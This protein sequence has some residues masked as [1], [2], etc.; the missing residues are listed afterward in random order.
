MN[1]RVSLLFLPL[2]FFFSYFLF[3]LFFLSLA[4][5]SDKRMSARGR[6]ET[7]LGRVFGRS[8]RARASSR[9]IFANGTR[10]LPLLQLGI[11]F[12]IPQSADEALR[13]DDVSTARVYADRDRR[14]LRHFVRPLTFAFCV[15]ERTPEIITSHG[16]RLANVGAN[17]SS[18]R[19]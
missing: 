3:F 2:F 17:E 15:S 12:F 4:R 6:A 11:Y 13:D 1:F 10:L 7:R 16:I 9:E 8:P 5:C 19:I 18:L 14:I